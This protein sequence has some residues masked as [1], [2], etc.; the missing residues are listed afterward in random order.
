LVNGDA[1]ADNGGAILADTGV[2]LA[3]TSAHFE[4]NTCEK[5]FGA[6]AA[7]ACQRMRVSVT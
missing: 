6:R 7:L 1:A 3:F 2:T 5:G 4:N